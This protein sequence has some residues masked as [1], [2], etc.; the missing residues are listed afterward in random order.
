[1]VVEFG[2][3]GFDALE[4]EIARLFEEGIDGE[5]EAVEIGV[6]RELLGERRVGERGKVGGEGEFG[7]GGLGGE[8]VEEGG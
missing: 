1:M 7:R 3:V 4:Q 5:V 6:E 8:L 2:V